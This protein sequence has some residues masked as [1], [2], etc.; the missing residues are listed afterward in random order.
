MIKNR[1]GACRNHD[2]MYGNF[3]AR[4]LPFRFT[5]HGPDYVSA[6]NGFGFSLFLNR[7]TAPAARRGCLLAGFCAYHC[8][9]F[10]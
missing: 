5:Y 6:G 2:E 1:E 8:C 9:C 4:A 7:L 3:P 10:Y